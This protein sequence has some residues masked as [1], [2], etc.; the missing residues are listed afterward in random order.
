V[1]F[2]EVRVVAVHHPDEFGEARRGLRVESYPESSR[3]RGNFRDEIGD[4]RGR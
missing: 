1:V 3:R 4:R 2:D